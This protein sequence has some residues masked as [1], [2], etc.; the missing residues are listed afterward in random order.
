MP[1][2]E[3]VIPSF[4]PDTAMAVAAV[5][6]PMSVSIDAVIDARAIRTLFQPVVHLGTGSVAGYEALTRGPA[7]S[8]LESPLALLAAARVAG[9]LGELDWVC[10]SQAM[11]AAA[12]A[13][14]P[15]SLS[16]L[17]NVEPAGLAMECPEPLLP[18]L[19]R[20]QADLRVILEVV[21]RDLHGNVLELIQTTDQAR[22]DCWGV[23]LDD[24]GAEEA[25]LALLPLLRPDVV[26]LDLTLI[27]GLPRTQAW[28]ITADVRSYAERTGAVILAEG[29]ETPEHERLAKL[30]GATYGQ[31]YLYGRPEPLPD[32]LPVPTHPIPLRQHL[33]PVDGRT[34][35]EVLSTTLTP[36][37]ESKEQ[38][39]HISAHLESE[40]GNG[41]QASVLL[42][43]FQRGKFFTPG[44]QAHYQ[45]LAAS[46]V[47]TIVLAEGLFRQNE[48][49]YHVGPLLDGSRLGNEWVVIVLNLHYA[50]AFVARDCGDTG[51]D[52]ARHFDFIFTHDRPS[53]IGAARSFVQELGSG[54]S[55]EP[56]RDP[57]AQPAVA[58][59]SGRSSAAP[60]ARV[61]PVVPPASAAFG[62]GHALAASVAA[63]ARGAS[64]F[65]AA[66]QLVL[67]FLNATMP[68]A[69]WSITRVE[70][71]RQTYLYL[72]HNEYG[73]T[74][75][76]SH[77]WS[78]SYCVR[79]V[80]GTGPR[81]A[82][83]VSR[84]PVYAAAA[85]NDAVPIGAYAGASIT[86]PDGSLFGAICGLDRNP[87]ADLTQFGP[88]L[89]LLSG[90][91]TVALASD[92]ALEDARRASLVTYDGEM[93]DPATGI[94]SRRA[95]DLAIARLD[96]DFA[97][98]A[99][100]TVIV[101]IELDGFELV[102]AGPGGRGAVEEQLRSAADI[103]R[104]ET[105]E[106]D[107]LA[108]LGGVEF[109]LILNG[110][111]EA[112]APPL[113]HRLNRALERAAIPA[114]VGFA[115]L[116]PEFTVHHAIYLADRAVFDAKSRAL[117]PRAAQATA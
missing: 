112:A 55:A 9:R 69:F 14:L 63:N 87:R 5:L 26:K 16:W 70:N 103:V 21:E 98:Y 4:V 102:L 19:R 58:Q 40:A 82:T 67:N 51:A 72:N 6:E 22:R 33:A 81:I 108:R 54:R 93:I 110:C 36:Q 100:P 41:S 12:D 47:L 76:G 17:V 24:V 43:G 60:V 3:F 114:S 115:A 44:K 57:Q 39:L 66:S 2:A 73:R 79:M 25:S 113:V 30:F 49:R 101:V 59:G 8:S 64:G 52:G 56:V 94:H 80:A 74:V 90:L 109:G 37:R 35:F 71:D 46:N 88:T 65:R 23:A 91:L 61:I 31:G 32:C 1:P 95:W 42:A 10:R 84:V 107:F 97:T 38:L 116:R 89:D 83:D 78:D 50:A 13:G 96:L 11:Q 75:G 85:I 106:H 68:M 27:R 117:R 99:D 104:R 111:E 29:I 53:V 34:P 20:A 18:V 48:P 92:R 77:P 45:E 105:R 7:G 62:P 86:E 15:E 28:A